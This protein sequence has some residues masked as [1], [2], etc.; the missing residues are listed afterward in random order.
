VSAL[1]IV[2]LAA[3]GYAGLLFLVAFIGDRTS[4]GGWL[5]SP[6]V[7]T[8]SI[9]VY[10]TSWTFYGAVGSAARNGLEFATI[11]IGP[12]LVF[13]GFYT[14]L[15][16]LLRIRRENNITSIADFISSR[17]GKS[18][19]IAA[20]VTLIA[21]AGAAP[22]IAL[23]LKAIT[24]SFQVIGGSPDTVGSDP[25]TAFWIAAG[26]ALFT[27]LFGT[28]SID[29]NERHYGVVAA[30]AV[31][32]I[33]KLVALIGVGLV[34]VYHVADGPQDIFNRITET[35]PPP[36]EGF[37]V[38][39]IGLIIL[40]GTAVLCLPRQ[41]QVTVVENVE[42]R[43]LFTAAWLF[44]LYLF[45]LSLFILPIAAVGATTLPPG[46]N[47]DMFVLT[48]P[49]AAGRDDI[50]LLA[51]LGGF[52]SATS[53][54]IVSCIA[55]ST[56]ISNHIVMP[57]TL[58]RTAGLGADG[59]VRALLLKSRRIAIC[60]I[61]L[62]GFLYLEFGPQ[63]AGLASIGLVAFL[64]VAQVLP[65]LLGALFWPRANRRGAMLGLAIGFVI[66]T[67][68]LLLPGLLADAGWWQR[69]EEVGP[70]GIDLLRPSALF[71]LSSVDPLMHAMF[72][73]LSANVLFFVLGSLSRD[74]SPL[75][76]LQSNL[77]V[78]AFRTS[79]DGAQQL[80]GRTASSDTLFDLAQRVMGPNRAYSIFQN[81]A[82]SQ[83]QDSE[84]PVPDDAFINHLERRMAASVGAASAR[85]MISRVAGG[86]RISLDEL[87]KI[88]DET[89]RLM[90]YSTRIEQKSRELEE[91]A[92]KLTH[93]NARLLQIDA[94]KDEFLSQ[95]S[96]ELRTPMTSIRSFS[97]ILAQNDR[98]DDDKS[99]YFLNIIHN[100]S[101]RL[102]RLLDEI[103]DIGAV[104]RGDDF[105]LSEIDPR[106]ALSRAI[107]AC[108]GLAASA[109]V[110]LIEQHTDMPAMVESN[111]DR[112]TQVFINIISNAIKYN[113][114]PAPQIE[115]STTLIDAT[116]RVSVADNGSG[117]AA[118]DMALIFDKFSRG[119]KPTNEKG[120]G[121]GLSISRAIMRK[122]AGD[123]VLVP[124]TEP[125]TRFDIVLP[126]ASEAKALA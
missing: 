119:S 36:Q 83:D 116:Y 50:A 66:W 74:L 5:R 117:I 68:T 17:Y 77:F 56:M 44:P 4:R 120:A 21:V 113:D 32:A 60:G 3:L 114:N 89:A 41:F 109:N 99:R 52:S 62:V 46:S 49:L 102:T 95:V 24:T 53:M 85:A 58:R 81:Y 13:L 124:S 115:I 88:A 25:F 48:M 38:R 91:T 6:V 93:A 84:F 101:V 51:F 22:Y 107:D 28:R 30:I 37:G 40:S 82:R 23:Q 123:V 97:E 11:Y 61:L 35:M 26:L 112:L 1:N 63:G 96:H 55:L 18:D 9:S 98:V 67:Y 72:W 69:V 79:R 90:E 31:E 27:I 57:L 73:S 87:V 19:L 10:C 7:Y 78:D 108:R 75:E 70:F 106:I 65:A 42:E 121:L 86:E 111:Q 103:L 125:G 105:P 104:E 118:D 59:D 43:H 94:Q 20:T 45:L 54:V 76:Q 39:W 80:V 47:P 110:Q 15:R 100:E 64:G 71:G 33:V 126:L 34:A 92:S 12:T 14:V 16:K 2:I 29:A 8:L 122:F